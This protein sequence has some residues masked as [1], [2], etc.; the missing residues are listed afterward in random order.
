MLWPSE[1]GNAYYMRTTTLFKRAFSSQVIILLCTPQRFAKGHN[2]AKHVFELIKG[3]LLPIN[4]VSQRLDSTLSAR[5]LVADCGERLVLK[6]GR[7]WPTFR[8]IVV[9]RSHRPL[10]VRILFLLASARLIYDKAALVSAELPF[11]II[12]SKPL[13]LNTSIPTSATTS[14][15]MSL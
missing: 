8:N 9:L 5:H 14:S 13:C 7:M 4:S 1:Y 12:R 6:L 3:K 15:R 11:P 10:R 2:H